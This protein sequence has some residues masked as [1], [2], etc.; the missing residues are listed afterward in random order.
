LKS[1]QEKGIVKKAQSMGA[2]WGYDG[3]GGRFRESIGYTDGPDA[4]K[5]ARKRRKGEPFAEYSKVHLF[6]LMDE[7]RY[8]AEGNSMCR[9]ELDDVPCGT[10]ICYD[11]GFPEMARSLTLKGCKVLFVPAQWPRPRIDHWKKLLQARATE[12][13]MYVVACNRAGSEGDNEF[14]GH[15]MIID[16][17]GRTIDEMPEGNEGILFAEID[18]DKVEEL[19]EAI[20]VFLD[21]RPLV[22]DV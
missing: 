18:V 12:N 2:L 10:L 8:L 7:Q 22:Y 16:P 19:R 14:P 5:P 15:S 1:F 20:P 11:I 4:R 3:G 6:R 17:W 9:F 13:Q 21:R